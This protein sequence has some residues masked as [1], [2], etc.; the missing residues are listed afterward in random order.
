[1]V[2]GRRVWPGCG[3][4]GGGGYW[5]D[6]PGVRGLL[7]ESWLMSPLS[8]EEIA[9]LGFE[10]V[11]ASAPVSI[12]VVDSSGQV[13]YS[14]ERARDLTAGLGRGMP[15]EL[16]RAIDI[17]HADGRRYRRHEWPVLRSITSGE[18][19]VDEEFFYAARDGGPLWVRCSSSPVRDGDGEIVA[20]VLAQTDV[21]ERKR[22][23]ARLAYLA[24]VLDNTEEAIIAFDVDWRVTAWNK[25]AQRM[26]GWA[27]DEAL[28]RELRTLMPVAMGG[29]QHA[30]VRREIAQRGRWRGEVTVGRRDG[31]V[32]SVESINVAIR[33]ADGKSTGYLAIHRDVTDRKRAEEA[34]RDAQ[35][36]SATILGR[37]TDSFCA[38]DSEWR[39]TYV[40]Q[41]AL[42]RIQ[43]LDGKPVTLTGLLGTSVWEAL[44]HLVGTTAEHELRRA[45]RAQRSVTFETYSPR[46]H[47]WLEVHAYPSEDGGLS[48]YARDITG[49]KA[50]EEQLRY[51][52]SLLENVEDGVIATD[53]EHLRVI[54]WNAGAERLYGFSAEE[55]LGQPA[56]QIASFPGDEGRLKLERELLETGRTRVEFTARRKDGSLVEVELS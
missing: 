32:F 33:D 15:T 30:A 1:M 14:N 29:E 21:S 35:R 31:S 23:E 50:T 46:T 34:L 25:G 5:V 51:H 52:A 11:I 47:E 55:V 22:E 13:I 26:Y 7:D 19:I 16:D 42:E 54:A 27:A 24:G 36:R 20:A 49:R 48:V 2:R 53:A 6:A 9:G 3:E 37:I 12:V 10:R 39:Y 28:G 8:S 18:E 38:V 17:F 40:N 44:P 43:E 41:R 45:V 4:L 56:R